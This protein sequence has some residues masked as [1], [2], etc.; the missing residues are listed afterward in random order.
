VLPAVLALNTQPFDLA[1]MLRR[2]LHHYQVIPVESWDQA[3]E[4]SQQGDVRAL[5]VAGPL[6]GGATPISLPVLSCSFSQPEALTALPE[7]VVSLEKPLSLE[8]VGHILSQVRSAARRVLVVSE[9]A[10]TGRVLTRMVSALSGP[11]VDIAQALD[12][13]T[14]LERYETMRPDV[15]FV[16]LDATQEQIDAHVID[17]LLERR[18]IP[19][20]AIIVAMTW[21]AMG[22]PLRGGPLILSS[23]T[24][25]SIS[26]YM[27][28]I[29]AILDVTYPVAANAPASTAAPD[30]PTE[31]PE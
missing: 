11:S 12:L 14:A 27:R 10:E 23:D 26:D 24:G 16:D 15:V 25:L 8:A 3:G 17:L 29:E 5:I 28:T 18:N 21:S 7:G 22:G 4:R 30:R 2:H 6:P 1:S 19:R 20:N 13:A 31:L 9:Y